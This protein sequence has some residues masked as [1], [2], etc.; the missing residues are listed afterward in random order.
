M[1]D[2]GVLRHRQTRADRG[3]A[4]VSHL[5]ALLPTLQDPGPERIDRSLIR[6][7][8][9]TP[10]GARIVLAGFITIPAGPRR[11]VPEM[12]GALIDGQI[13]ARAPATEIRRR[14]LVAYFG[15]WRRGGVHM[16][17]VIPDRVAR[18][19]Y[20]IPGHAPI[21]AVVHHNVATLQ[22]NPA[23]KFPGRAENA[24]TMTWYAR[25]GK[26]MKRIPSLS[27][28]TKRA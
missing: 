7:A 3:H 20:R 25:D 17:V 6:I 1:Q 22:I 21:D 15:I 5:R 11:S 13:G 26:L 9:T 23:P 8:G 28:I 16:V 19:V 14:G 4:L 12:L 24:A 27:S 2:L 10:W 18:I